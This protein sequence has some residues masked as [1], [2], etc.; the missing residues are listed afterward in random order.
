MEPIK[1]QN[2]TIIIQ[3]FFLPLL[4]R[5]PFRLRKLTGPDGKL[6]IDHFATSPD[7][8]FYSSDGYRINPL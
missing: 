6:L 4:L 5:S 2:S 8:R 1:N 7:L 3:Q